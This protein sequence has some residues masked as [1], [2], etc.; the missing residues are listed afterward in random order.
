[1]NQKLYDAVYAATNTVTTTDEPHRLSINKEAFETLVG[2]ALAASGNS[3]GEQCLPF[4]EALEGYIDGIYGIA[5][6]YQIP[7][8]HAADYVKHMHSAVIGIR[9]RLGLPWDPD[10]GKRT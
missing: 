9:R 4:L 6:K 7:A 5:I 10:A 3:L 8:G 2:E 1:M